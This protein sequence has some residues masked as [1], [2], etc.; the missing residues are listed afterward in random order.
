MLSIDE[1][2]V[3]RQRKVFTSRLGTRACRPRRDFQHPRMWRS[4]EKGHSRLS[5]VGCRFGR[6][7]RRNAGS[8]GIG[9]LQRVTRPRLRDD[10]GIDL[11]GDEDQVT[12]SLVV[13]L[14]RCGNEAVPGNHGFDLDIAYC[15]CDDFEMYDRVSCVERTVHIR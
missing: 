10:C 9:L 5:T 15:R 8:P 12:L 14:N 4:P 1:R 2:R 6:Q 3:E 13:P 7:P 11:V